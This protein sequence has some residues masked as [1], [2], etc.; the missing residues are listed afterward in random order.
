MGLILNQI[1]GLAAAVA[2]AE[3]E[4]AAIREL[5]F[6]GEHTDICG[7][8]AKLFTLW[9]WTL[10]RAARSPFLGYDSEID[11]A[12]IMQFLWI[13]SPEFV[14]G[15]TAKRDAFF[16]VIAPALDYDLAVNGI[17]DYLAESLM[18]L[19]SRSHDSDAPVLS[20]VASLVHRMA[21]AYG[22]GTNG[23]LAFRNEIL[24]MPLIELAQ[25]RRAI[26]MDAGQKFGNSLSGAARRN[27]V[28]KALAAHKAKPQQSAPAIDFQI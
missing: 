8:P 9:H 20:F 7:I 22:I 4:E 2:A 25:Y 28:A 21:A 24:H 17:R 6:F 1:P 23:F 15:D 11:G 26:L 3:A 12:A 19:V 14:W 16:A 18:D 5:P 10:L 13:V 27:H